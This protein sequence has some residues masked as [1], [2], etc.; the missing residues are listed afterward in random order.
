VPVLLLGGLSLAGCA[1]AGQR[2]AREQRRIRCLIEEL[3]G[4]DA[5]R[6]EAAADDLGAVG[7][8]AA[9]AV[10][11]LARALLD[12]RAT[13]DLRQAVISA[14]ARIGPAGA[15]AAAAL[16]EARTRHPELD[17]PIR[18]AMDQIGS[19]LSE[20]LVAVQREHRNPRVR[21]EAA[22]LLDGAAGSGQGEQRLIVALR[23]DPSAEV[24]AE[25]ARTL[26]RRGARQAIA[27]LRLAL[28]DESW[29]VAV[30]AAEALAALGPEG[31]KVLREAARRSPP[32]VAIAAALAL[33]RPA[34][35]LP[36][37]DWLA[38]LADSRWQ[39]RAAAARALGQVGA[40][41]AL[42]QL[43]GDPSAE[44]QQAAEDAIAALEARP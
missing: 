21:A 28:A 34:P 23:R 32:L 12:P 43:R 30:A 27:A 38:A 36:W 41:E 31:D 19:P 4:D 6:R 17:Q 35:D 29:P 9:A 8:S 7:S 24:R 18:R 10:P 39:V 37:R 40:T 42:E 16:V 22:R 3:R 11:T 2:Q 26:G 14:L 20:K 44:V 5:D 1:S 13:S 33:A 15:G 25:A